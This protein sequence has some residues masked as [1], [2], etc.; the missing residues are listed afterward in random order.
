MG[1]CLFFSKC[2][3]LQIRNDAC[4]S[5]IILCVWGLI[6]FHTGNE[7]PLKTVMVNVFAIGPGFVRIP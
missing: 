5:C 3:N 7:E 6:K 4:Y 1:R 2:S